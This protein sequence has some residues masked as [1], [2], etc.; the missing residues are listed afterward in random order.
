MNRHQRCA[1]RDGLCFALP[2][3]K[4]SSAT[5]HGAILGSEGLKGD[6]D[7]ILED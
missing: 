2:V 3:A 7:F 6:L 5:K 4:T 1:H